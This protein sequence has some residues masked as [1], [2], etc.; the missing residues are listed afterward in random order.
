MNSEEVACTE[1]N[2]TDRYGRDNKALLF[3]A[4][5]YRAKNTMESS[6]LRI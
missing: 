6:F 2:T 1:K 5:L 4:L 3:F